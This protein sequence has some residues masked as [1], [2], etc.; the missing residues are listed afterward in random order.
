[1]PQSLA[2]ILVHTVFSTN[3]RRLFL[4]DKALPGRRNIIAMYRFR[5]SF[6]NCCD[7]TRLN[8]MNATSGTDSTLSGLVL[9]GSV[10][11]GSSFLA[12]LGSV[13]QSLWDW[14]GLASY[15]GGHRPKAKAKAWG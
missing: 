12:T 13:I 8:S 9:I 3:H 1:M 14:H 10:T 15:F 7:V 5:T 11:Q 6:G 4:R 2:K